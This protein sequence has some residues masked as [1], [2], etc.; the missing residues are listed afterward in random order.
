MI[1]IDLNTSKIIINGF[2]PITPSLAHQ[3][4]QRKSYRSWSIWENIE[5]STCNMT[6][7]TKEEEELLERI[8]LQ[9][10]FPVRLER[11]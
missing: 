11:K 10:Y 4:L 8:E 7:S 1:I 6:R 3:P 9:A 5:L 2:D